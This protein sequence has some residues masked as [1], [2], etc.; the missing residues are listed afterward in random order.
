M[1]FSLYVGSMPIT[2]GKPS[3]L[4]NGLFPDVTG[5]KLGLET[6]CSV[7]DFSRPSSGPP[8]QQYLKRHHYISFHILP[9]FI[10]SLH[11]I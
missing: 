5:A 7:R 11:A 9:N 3:L 6:C 8:R 1:K 4:G 10:L 2:F